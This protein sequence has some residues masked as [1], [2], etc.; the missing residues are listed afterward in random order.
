MT[1]EVAVAPAAPA[2]GPLKHHKSCA[3]CSEY[4][5]DYTTVCADCEDVVCR[6]CLLKRDDKTNKNWDYIKTRC[7]ETEMCR[8]CFE[9]RECSACDK[10]GCNMCVPLQCEECSS[11]RRWTVLCDDCV[12]ACKNCKQL[13]ICPVH[14]VMKCD[15]VEPLCRDCYEMLVDEKRDDRRNSAKRKLAKVRK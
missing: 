12:K 7:C 3:H 6:K 2:K 1:T 4:T 14:K 8:S 11:G 9:E 15:G 10:A 13:I 5:R